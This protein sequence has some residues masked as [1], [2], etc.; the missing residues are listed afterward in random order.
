[1]RS[2][3]LLL[4]SL[5]GCGGPWDLDLAR[6]YDLELGARHACTPPAEGPAFFVRI[7]GDD[8]VPFAGALAE[9][10]DPDDGG[11]R[12]PDIERAGVEVALWEVA[13]DSR[14]P[15]GE[16][17]SA[18][19]DEDGRFSFVFDPAGFEGRAASFAVNGVVGQPLD[20]AVSPSSGAGGDLICA[21]WAIGGAQVE[22]VVSLGE[23]VE[24][25]AHGTGDL[26]PPIHAIHE[27]GSDLSGNQQ[28]TT[29]DGAPFVDG[30]SRTPWTVHAEP[31]FL[32]GGALELLFHTYASVDGDEYNAQA[33]TSPWMIAR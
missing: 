22:R 5:V 25:V 17:V 31:G 23:E 33:V 14:E 28:V 7:V 18:E 26:D 21:Y 12:G 30:V 4:L 6:V 11:P 8:P 9:E 3:C 29:V 24:L 10:R 27:V 13:V 15:I 19:T 20:F 1:M 2:S 16:L 32:D